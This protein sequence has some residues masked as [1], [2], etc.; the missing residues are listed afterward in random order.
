MCNARLSVHMISQVW[1]IHCSSSCKLS[2][3]SF[4]CLSR[5]TRYFGLAMAAYP[6]FFALYPTAERQQSI[7]AL[8]YSNGVSPLPLWLSYILFDF[9]WV[10]IISVISTILLTVFYSH[11]YQ[12]GYIFVVS[13][14]YGLCSVLLSF[15]ISLF[16]KSQL[17]AFAFCAG[18]QAIGYLIYIIVYL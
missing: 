6:A 17:S 5:P 15:I 16:S 18:G 8:Q 1:A 9:S 14:L 4:P 7:R 11:W 10:L 13:L 12:L 2:H 3:L